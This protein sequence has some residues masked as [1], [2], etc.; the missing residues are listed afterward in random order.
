V[1]LLL[2]PTPSDDAAQALRDIDGFRARYIAT[3]AIDLVGVLLL[4]SGL[5]A[6]GRLQL[7]AG[8]GAAAIIGGSANAAGGALI[9]LT[10]VLQSTVEPA[11]AERFVAASTEGQAAAL[12]VGEA[13]I[14]VSGAVFGTAFLLQMLGIALVAITFLVGSGPRINRPFL[15][16]G[17]LLALGASTMGIGALF[18][19]TLGRVEA[20]LGLVALLWLVVLAAL[21]A[22]APEG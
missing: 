6:L 10:L 3:N 15:I 11:V 19:D 1:G 2:G 22:R 5:I 8:G 21:V 20:L 7:L 12:A 14:E 9:A 16:V 13:V 17:A 18:E 4:A